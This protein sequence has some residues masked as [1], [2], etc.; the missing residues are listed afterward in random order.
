MTLNIF[1]KKIVNNIVYNIHTPK[2]L[3]PK[4]QPWAINEFQLSHME[5]IIQDIH[6]SISTRPFLGLWC[7]VPKHVIILYLI[8]SPSSN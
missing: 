6:I 7:E 8:L 3:K 2:P 1:L 5:S 4:I